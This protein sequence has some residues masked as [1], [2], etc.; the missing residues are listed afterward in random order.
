MVTQLKALLR[1]GDYLLFS[2]NLTP[3]GMETILPQYDNQLT[4]D[5]L[6]EFPK[7]H[8][9]GRGEVRVAIKSE[10]DLEYISASFIF[11]ESCVME[12]SENLF[13][14]YPGDSLQLFVSYRYSINSLAR[15]LEPYGIKI[16]KSFQSRNGEE[17]V[18]ICRL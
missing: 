4:R 10:D 12:A 14:F 1:P 3:N 6:A 5:W 2:A 18:F 13:K 9:A 11:Q 15:T 16:E 7:S 8:G 17:G